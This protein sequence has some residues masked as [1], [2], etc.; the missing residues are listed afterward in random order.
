MS[1]E[2]GKRERPP[3]GLTKDEL[4][5]WAKKK[6]AEKKAAKASPEAKEA[7]AEQPPKPTYT[8]PLAVKI[9]ERLESELSGVSVDYPTRVSAQVSPEKI[10]YVLSVLKA[11]F[12]FEQLIDISAVDALKLPDADPD[13]MWVVYHISSYDDP[14]VLML[15]TILPRENP[16]TFSVVDIF[17]N[18]SWHE[19]EIWEMFGVDFEGNLELKPLF[20][21]TDL[22][23]EH[24]L[25][26]DYPDYPNPYNKQR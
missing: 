21:T 25:R 20:L 3:E 5:E 10:H 26:K 1:N 2:G 7:V 15:K 12:G 13:T 14:T 18:A 19:R 16:K 22:A 9:K 23:Q 8:N 11:E 24:P 6:A 17:W 4:R